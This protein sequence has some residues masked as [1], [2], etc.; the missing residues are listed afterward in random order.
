MVKSLFFLDFGFSS[1]AQESKIKDTIKKVI[2][3]NLF[4]T[5]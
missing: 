3:I 4:K 5:N 1:D 2:F